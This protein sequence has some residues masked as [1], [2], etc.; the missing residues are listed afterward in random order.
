[1]NNSLYLIP[2]LQ[3]IILLIKISKKKS[4]KF[5]SHNFDTLTV[6]SFI[7][8]GVRMSPEVQSNFDNVSLA[9]QFCLALWQLMKLTPFVALIRGGV[10]WLLR[11]LGFSPIYTVLQM[12]SRE[13]ELL[14]APRGYSV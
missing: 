3:N 5:Q 10:G 8:G 1:V 7:I 6:L 12:F 4:T 11:P 2:F 13:S 9:L 14:C